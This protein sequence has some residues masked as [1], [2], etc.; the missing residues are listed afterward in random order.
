MRSQLEGDFAEAIRQV[1]SVRETNR[2][3]GLDVTP[4]FDRV[5]KTYPL[6]DLQNYIAQNYGLTRVTTGV[7]N[8]DYTYLNEKMLKQFDERFLR[9]DRLTLGFRYGEDWKNILAFRATL[10]NLAE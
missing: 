9:Y 3:T 6:R 8:E 10:V 7:G 1:A 4:Q 5:T 2:S